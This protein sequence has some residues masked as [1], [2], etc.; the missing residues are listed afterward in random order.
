MKKCTVGGQAVLEG[1][2]MKAPDAMAIAV[3]CE[4]GTID[5]KRKV[6]NPASNRHPILK[7]PIIR[8]LLALVRPW[9]RDK[10]PYG[11]C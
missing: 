3:R 6:L 4:D 8:G 1:V 11:L 7:L 9:S 2:M 10:V 5:V